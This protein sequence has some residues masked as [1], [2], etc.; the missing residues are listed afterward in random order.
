MGFVSEIFTSCGAF[1]YQDYAVTIP[2]CCGERCK[3]SRLRRRRSRQRRCRR[4]WLF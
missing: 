4:A 1:G 3:H 2:Y